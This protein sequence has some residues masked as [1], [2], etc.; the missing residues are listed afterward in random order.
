[1]AERGNGW[2]IDSLENI[3]L[4]ATEGRNFGAACEFLARGGFDALAV[5]KTAIDGEKVFVNCNETQYSAPEERRPELHRRYFDIHVPLTHDERIGLATLDPAA[6]IQ[7]SEA[8]DCG[9]CDVPVEWRTI[10]RGEFCI[11]SPGTCAHAPAVAT[12]APCVARKLV[13][14]VLA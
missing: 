7:F 6:E 13:V 14:K 2:A 8:D 5:G 10:R 11:V 3:G 1:M 4:Y 9:F 12:G